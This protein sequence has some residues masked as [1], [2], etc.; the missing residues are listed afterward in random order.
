MNGGRTGNY[1]TLYGESV[2]DIVRK[3]FQVGWNARG[4]LS[5]KQKQHVNGYC[6]PSYLIPD[7]QAI[8][9]NPDNV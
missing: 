3:A 5:R 7:D 4:E 8:A 6:A 9:E 2:K 1:D